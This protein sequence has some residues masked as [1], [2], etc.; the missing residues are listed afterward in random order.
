MCAP[1]AARHSRTSADGLLTTCP[2]QA[3]NLFSPR[4]PSV[5]KP[6]KR[7]QTLFGS[8][9]AIP[10]TSLESRLIQHMSASPPLRLAY[11]FKYAAVAFV[12]AVFVSVFVFVFVS[13][14]ALLMLRR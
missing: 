2:L 13:C 1:R 8:N 11:K 7:L 5:I 6:D 14:I 10:V 9:A 3:R 4:D 12:C